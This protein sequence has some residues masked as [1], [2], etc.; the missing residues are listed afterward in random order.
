MEARVA[1]GLA[2]GATLDELA[3]EGSVS[4]NTVRTQLRAVFDCKCDATIN[5]APISATPYVAL[6]KST[7]LP[8][9]PKVRNGQDREMFAARHLYSPDWLGS[10]PRLPAELAV[11][12][13]AADV[14][15]RFE[16]VSR[17]QFMTNSRLSPGRPIDT[18]GPRGGQSAAF[19]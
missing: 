9:T 16:P 4:R 6:W 10:D 12:A 2:R 11:C 19:F 17:R 15:A 18:P 13:E 14:A 1:N 3:S 5:R 7:G 8:G